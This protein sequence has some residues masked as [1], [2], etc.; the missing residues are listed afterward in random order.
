VRRIAAPGG[1][2]A[3]LG[4][5][6]AAAHAALPGAEGLLAGAAHPFSTPGQVL[7]LLALGLMGGLAPAEGFSRILCAFAPAAVLGLVVGL[8]SGGPPIWAE[9]ALLAAASL[10]GGLAALAP[11]AAAPGL[12][13]AGAGGLLLGAMA[14][15][16]P[17]PLPDVT[18][19]AAGG[20][21][22]AGLAVVYAGGGAGWLRRRAGAPWATLGL[23][24]AASWVAAAAVLMLALSLSASG[25]G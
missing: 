2:A 11:G 1:L 16:E 10:A 24:V 12:G 23:R 15:P 8:W 7:A 6:G 4:P 3:G 22:G 19:T 21:T 18:F 13:L 5:G 17:G 9:A 20:L 14:T 25:T